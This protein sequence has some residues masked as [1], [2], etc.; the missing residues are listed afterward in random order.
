M[1]NLLY[2]DWVTDDLL[3]KIEKDPVL[4]EAFKDPALTQALTQFQADPQRAL[5]AAKDK[6]KVTS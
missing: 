2:S 5:A 6:P 4:S 1:Y 3:E